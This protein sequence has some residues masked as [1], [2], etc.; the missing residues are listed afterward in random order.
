MPRSREERLVR[1]LVV[2]LAAYWLALGIL[3]V[4]APHTFYKQVGPF[5]PYNRHYVRDN[6]TFALAFGI[7]LLVS[8]RIASWR[9]PVIAVTVIQGAF[10]T[11][12][13]L[14]D[15]SHAHPKRYGPGDAIGVGLFTL[16]SWWVMR[17]AGRASAP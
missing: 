12:N 10:H 1:Y 2:A 11:I 8:L 13:H 4:V 16:F 17:R 9:V 6:A 14:V 5:G 3:M 15:I 7:A